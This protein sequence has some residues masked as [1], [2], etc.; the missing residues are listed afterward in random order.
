MMETF[1]QVEKTG[2]TYNLAAMI[3]NMIRIDNNRITLSSNLNE[4]LAYTVEVPATR[5][6]IMEAFG[7]EQKPEW[8]EDL[9]IFFA[10]T[11]G[12]IKQKNFKW[13]IGSRPVTGPHKFGL[14]TFIP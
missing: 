2:K 10:D 8:L 9:L 6:Q 13:Y 14:I 11:A 3:R 12:D 7:A 4:R 1:H 5:Q